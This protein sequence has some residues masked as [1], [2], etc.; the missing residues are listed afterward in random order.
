MDVKELLFNN[1]RGR[2]RDVLWSAITQEADRIEREKLSLTDKQK[3]EVLYNA[4][5]KYYAEY[6]SLLEK[7]EKEE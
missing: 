6:E 5:K 4:T 2:V 3:I 1:V 7:M